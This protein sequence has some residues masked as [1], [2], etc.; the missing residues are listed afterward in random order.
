MVRLRLK[1]MGRRNRPFYR[2]N[3][4][5]KREKRDGK[6]LENLGWYDPVSQDENKQVSLKEE[7]IKHWLGR[8]AQA[9]DTVND[10]LA[11]HGVIDAE[12]W[13]SERAGRYGKKMD[14]IHKRKQAEEE[15]AKA[16]AEA[17]AKAKAEEEA[18]KA[19]E[20]AEAEKASEEAPAEA[21]AE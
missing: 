11:K 1:R 18:K 12:A 8:G 19:A 14:T 21:A 20:A 17:E 9:S 7:R 10:L 4:I 13:Q 2:L 15:A 6:V 3:A 5:E 16:A